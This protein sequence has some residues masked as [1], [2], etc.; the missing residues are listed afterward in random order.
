MTTPRMPNALAAASLALAALAAAPALA[1]TATFRPV[2]DGTLI[3]PN[4]GGQYS[5]G[6]AYNIYCG[7]VGTNGGGTFRRALVRFDLTS[8]PAGSTVLSVSLRTYMSQTN[9]GA[10]DCRL[11]RMQEAWGEGASFAFGGGGTSPE[12]NDVTWTHRVW[13][14]ATWSVPGGV[15]APVAS[16]VRSVNAIGSYTW[17][18]TPALVA[19][20]QAWVSAP[21]TNFGWVIV[22]NEAVLESAKRFESRESADV[23]RHPTLVV[24][25]TPGNAPPGDLDGNGRI[26]GADLGLL[27]NAWGQ[28]GVPADLNQSGTVEGG[29]LGLLLS[30]WNP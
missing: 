25:Y 11:H 21:A 28:S 10:Q 7:R 2:A 14:S 16:A 27:L 23:T 1:D 18:T 20:V 9:S 24:T 26:D 29:D 4:D 12:A 15:Y 8:I 22:G 19:D 5:L 30:N 17:A 6:A 13:P 3:Q